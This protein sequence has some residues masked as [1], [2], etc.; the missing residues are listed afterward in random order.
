VSGELPPAIGD[1]PVGAGIASYRIDQLVGRGGMASVYRATD[2]RLDRPVALKVLTPQLSSDSGFRQRF[3]RESR[4][5]ASVDHPNIIPIFE[6]G[7]SDGVLFIA[8]RYVT[9]Q[10]VRALIEREGR[11]SPARTVSIVTQ[12]ASALDTAHARGLIHRDVKPANMLL[13]TLGTATT[14]DHVYLSDFGLSKVS[15]SAPSLT[16]TG[17]FLGTIDYMSPE[18]V[19]GRPIDGR[20]D[21][22]ALACAAFEMLTGEPPFRRE[23]NLAVMWAQVSAPPPSVR[24]LRPDLPAEVD[25]VLGKALAKAPDDRQSSCMEF[26][27][28]L[29]SACA[30]AAPVPLGKPTPQP[31]EA[32]AM[33]GL[34]GGQDAWHPPTAAIGMTPAGGAGPAGEAGPGGYQP[35]YADTVTE[36]AVS[37]HPGPAQPGPAQPGPA[38]PAPA[39]PGLA[40]DRAGQ[41]DHLWPGQSG[42]PQTYPGPY[43]PP[44]RRSKAAPVLV[45]LL[46]VAILAGGGYTLLRLRGNPT[47]QSSSAPP[48]TKTVTHTATH[49]HSANPANRTPTKPAAVVTAYYNA[50]NNHDWRTAWRLNQHVHSLQTYQQFKG[51]FL[52]TEYTTLTIVSVSGDV[53]TMQLAATQTSG[54][55]KHYQGTY[56]VQH[57]TIVDSAVQ[58]IGSPCP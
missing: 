33:P 26:A 17:Q 37:G 40:A 36:G 4:S 29:E 48:V 7:E 21:L 51:G 6:A 38:R 56:T 15:V 52:G 13:A 25:R 45:G 23:Q 49:S 47:A 19:E 22:Y 2:V 16:G 32:V 35:G 10:D 30:A 54:V 43:P 8:M 11:I 57:G 34:A 12:V 55:G 46:V 53:V 9:G 5:A 58:C 14:P 42:G 39:Q 44:R 1:L 27:A 20:T 18:Q 41:T 28:E 50:V 3:I 24:D 31:T